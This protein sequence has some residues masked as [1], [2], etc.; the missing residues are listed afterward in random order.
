MSALAKSIDARYFGYRPVA[1]SHAAS[2]PATAGAAG[3][4]SVWRLRLGA[5]SPASLPDGVLRSRP[6]DVNDLA[7]TFSAEP[8]PQ[9]RG[10]R[11]PLA[12]PAGLSALWALNR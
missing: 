5:G 8:W 12:A 3:E 4:W 6:D 11:L 10:G 9:R 7:A 1:G 2:A